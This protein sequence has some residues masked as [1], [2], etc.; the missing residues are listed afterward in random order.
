MHECKEVMTM[1]TLND[2]IKIDGVVAVGESTADGELVN[3][4]EN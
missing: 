2:L 1:V 3:Y 4:E